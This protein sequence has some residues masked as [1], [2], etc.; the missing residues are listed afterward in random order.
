MRLYKKMGIQQKLTA[1]FSI[2]FILPLIVVGFFS[3]TRSADII[4]KKNTDYYKQSLNQTAQNFATIFDDI[5]NI[6]YLLLANDD[7][8]YILNSTTMDTDYFS[9][10]NRVNLLVRNFLLK[11]EVFSLSITNN[12][13]AL[14]YQAGKIVMIEDQND[15]YRK[16]NTMRG[17]TIWSSSHVLKNLLDAKPVNAVSMYRQIID[18]DLNKPIGTIRISVSEDTLHSKYS[19]ISSK[20]PEQIFI[21][22]DDGVVISHSDKSLIGKTTYESEIIPAIRDNTGFYSSKISNGRYLF[23]QR[24]GDSKYT[25]IDIVPLGVIN[26]ERIIIKNFLIYLLIGCFIFVLL[27]SNIV[28]LYVLNPIKILS[29]KMNDVKKGNF[30]VSVKVESEDEIGNLAYHFNDMVSR[31]KALIKELYEVKLKEREAELKALQAQINPHFL[32]NTLDSI[33]WTAR[34]NKDFETSEYVEVLSDMLRY[35]L[36]NRGNIT[37][38]QSELMNLKNYIFLQKKRIDDNIKIT[39][40]FDDN[41]L[42]YKIYKLSLQPLVENSLKHGLADSLEGGFVHVTGKMSEEKIYITVAD[43]GSGTDA[44]AINEIINSGRETS[45]IY[46]LKNINERIKLNFGSEYGLTVK[47]RIGEG[48]E[49]IM[50]IPAVE[51]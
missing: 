20:T 31:I 14:Y 43:N 10:Y 29:R 46:A 36:D 40:E 12:N 50:V 15:W 47:S 5:E 21:L 28:S 35:S 18:L 45:K 16:A 33:R 4:D 51:Y 38:I 44:A 22:D 37:D 1:S 48:C 41:I 11:P 42:K 3:Y 9:S 19:N 17:V 30:D 32:Y 25:I 39:I 7:V 49:V 13:G 2:L 23:A 24:I 27:I 6:S 34:Q 8:R 26:Y